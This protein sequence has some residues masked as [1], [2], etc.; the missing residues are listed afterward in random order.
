MTSK[1]KELKEEN[2]GR[3]VAK[4]NIFSLE[5]NLEG[6]EARLPQIKIL[7]N[8]AQMFL[9]PD[10]SKVESFKG[11]ILDKNRANAW[12][13]IP[14]DESGG[15][16]IPDCFSNDGI[17]PSNTSLNQKSELC[18]H[19]P[20]GGKGAFGTEIRNGKKGRGK[21][22]K[23]MYR[24]HIMVLDGRSII[25]SR[26][27][28]SP[29][30]LSVMDDYIVKVSGSGYLYQVI[31]T[32]FSLVEGKNADGIVFSSLVL[33]PDFRSEITDSEK[34]GEIKELRD[35]WY[36]VMRNQELTSEEVR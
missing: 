3:E 21:A 11:R 20:L 24:V 4:N 23:N 31:E 14:Y 26:L 33:E 36:S 35:S 25:P 5:E 22:C 9:M 1:N 18:V 10:G 12:W 15:N 17:R 13:E 8:G 27:T 34:Q 16:D 6:I 30:N 28:L 29:G 2:P 19:C 32:K 7:H